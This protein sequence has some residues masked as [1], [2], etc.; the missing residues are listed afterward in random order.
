MVNFPLE[1]VTSLSFCFFVLFYLPVFFF[2]F[3]FFFSLLYVFGLAL[4]VKI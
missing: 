2:F 4:L 3:F 1:G